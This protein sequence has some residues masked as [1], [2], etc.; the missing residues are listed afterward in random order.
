MIKILK[1][2][3]GKIIRLSY[4]VCYRLV[5]S[6]QQ[7]ILFISFH[8]KGYSDN[9]KAIHEYMMQQEA[10]KNYRFI[11]AIKHHKSKN[12]SIS[13]AKIIEYFS[14]SYFYY[15]AR[16]K[17]WI[18]NCKL[19]NY[20]L[21]KPNQIYLQTWHGTPLK[22]LAHDIEVPETTTFYRSGMSMHEMHTTYDNDVSKYN[23]MISP[24]SFTTKVFQSAFQI[25]AKRLLEI[26]YPRNDILSV[27]TDTMVQEMKQKYRLPSDKK[28]ILYA[29]T[30]RDNSF[31]M[32]GYTFSLEVD[33]KLWQEILGDEYIVLFKPHYLIV[34]DF[35]IEQFK[36]FVYYI[37]PEKD[38]SDLYIIS[39]I[40][41]TDYSSV[42]FDYAILEKPIYFYM[43]DLDEY[44]NELRGFYLDI[45]QELPGPIFENE[46]EM[47]QTIQEQIFDY[48]VVSKFNERFNNHED[49]NASKRAVDAIIR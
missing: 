45:Y 15:L 27:Y 22:K 13:N 32:K 12:I 48:Q 2:I 49:G 39:D 11:W 18:V 33:F 30:W 16:S 38:I 10:Y 25:E 1:K 23:Y 8:G 9:P 37:E 3:A 20:V 19:P 47:L 5:P 41:I 24:S 44:K 46:K 4:R 35:N 43:Y 14:I 26:G 6:Q 17:Y 36:D 40:L 7:T 31:N 28:V 21:K 34:N 29:P 42:F